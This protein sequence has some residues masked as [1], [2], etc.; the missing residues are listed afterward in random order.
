MYIHVTS[1]LPIDNRG[2]LF[3]SQL[4]GTHSRKP[5]Y[6][7]GPQNQFNQSDEDDADDDNDAFGNDND[8]DNYDDNACGL[9]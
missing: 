1:L 7:Q 9:R 2:M 6:C 3:T 4:V 5:L 8:V